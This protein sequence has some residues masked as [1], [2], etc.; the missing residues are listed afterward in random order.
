MYF[1]VPTRV[2][3][4]YWD[5][6]SISKFGPKDL[7]VKCIIGILQCAGRTEIIISPCN[8]YNFGWHHCP[9]RGSGR[10][11]S[12]MMFATFNSEI[13]KQKLNAHYNFLESLKLLVYLI[14]TIRSSPTQNTLRYR[15]NC[16]STTVVCNI[17]LLKNLAVISVL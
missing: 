4:E 6:K 13:Q 10:G 3:G 2:H 16:K 12:F 9:P 11:L 5:Y 1:K 17:S 7:K 8:Y 15:N 14:T